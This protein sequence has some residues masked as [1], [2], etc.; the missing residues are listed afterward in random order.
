MKQ[1]MLLSIVMTC[2]FTASATGILKA[3]EHRQE[4]HRQQETHE[5]GIGELNVAMDEN[6]LMI[7]LHTP[8]MNI[9]G[10][11]HEPATPEQKDAVRQANQTLENPGKMFELSPKGKCK[12]VSAKSELIHSDHEEDADAEHHSD[13]EEDAEHQEEEGGHAEFHVNYQFD[14]ASPEKI[15]EIPVKIFQ[16]FPNTQKLKLQLITPQHQSAQ[17]LTP[18]APVI[19]FSP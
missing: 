2:I 14:C 15:T 7:E 10:F 3:G 5:H 12:V 4:E 8:G 11:E 17:T 16:V 9:V 18:Q 1:W 19:R 13:H 6:Q